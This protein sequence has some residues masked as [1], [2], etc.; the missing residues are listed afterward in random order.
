MG[1]H[2]TGLPVRRTVPSAGTKLTMHTADNSERREPAASAVRVRLGPKST[3][4]MAELGLQVVTG[5]LADAAKLV[6]SFDDRDSLANVIGGCACT[7]RS[8]PSRRS[9][10]PAGRIGRFADAIP[11]GKAIQL[12]LKS[13]DAHNDLGNALM[14]LSRHR[15][16]PH[17]QRAVALDP[18]TRW[19]IFSLGNAFKAL[20]G[21]GPQPRISDV[22][23]IQYRTRASISGRADGEAL[24][25]SRRP[26]QR[27]AQAKPEFGGDHNNG[28][29]ADAARRFG[30]AMKRSSA[31]AGARP[32]YARAEGAAASADS[33]AAA[34]TSGVQAGSV[35]NADLS[36][37]DGGHGRAVMNAATR[38]TIATLALVAGGTISVTPCP[39]HAAP[40]A[41]DRTRHARQ[42]RQ[43]LVDRHAQTT[44][45][46]GLAAGD[47]HGQALSADQQ[48]S[49]RVRSSRRSISPR[50]SRRSSRGT[51]P[52]PEG[53]RR[54][55]RE[56]AADIALT[57]P[58]SVG[59]RGRTA[60]ISRTA[61][62]RA[63]PRKPTSPP[64][65]PASGSPAPRSR[66]RRSTSR[67]Q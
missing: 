50:I 19:P 52:A 31:G 32:E 5:S 12:D 23:L 7:G 60:E 46:V 47:R 57:R 40:R 13:A 63:G 18:R 53:V 30:D 48:P 20:S 61:E 54:L 44:T 27:A 25:G 24:P 43:V 67:R 41:R 9:W 39:S 49:G 38:S 15:A 10:A 64:P 6:Q 42:H 33:G 36:L 17:F 8:R 3:D 34:L 11:H 2:V 21:P 26:F 4:E 35:S 65:T 55:H 1:F 14:A 16:L 37:V 58:R 51:S 56:S 62:T 28:Q 22:R 59:G 45:T 29:R 66:W